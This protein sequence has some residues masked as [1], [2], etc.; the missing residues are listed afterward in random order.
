MSFIRHPTAVITINTVAAP[1]HA[2]PAMPIE[3]PTPGKHYE[4]HTETCTGTD[5]ENIGSG[6]RITEESLHLKAAD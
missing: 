2:A 4:C 1:V 3:E 5:A 6:K